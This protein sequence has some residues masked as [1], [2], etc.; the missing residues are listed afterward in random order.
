[1]ATEVTV[2]KAETI[3]M[4]E[5]AMGV[6]DLLRTSKSPMGVNAIAKQCDL[7]PS[8][9]FRILKTLEKTGWVYQ[10]E[11][12]RYITGHKLSFVTEKNNFYM[13]LG[14]AAK[15]VME[16]CTAHHGLAMNLI[17]RNGADCVILEQ[18]LTKS[19][20]NYVPPL[21]STLPYYAC[22]GGKIL[23]CELPDALVESLIRTH[24]M[25]ALTPFTITDP[26]AYI[27]ELKKTAENGYAI[28]FQESSINGSCIAV[29]V[30]DREG[31][32]IASLSFS[33]LIGI[34][35]PSKLLKYLPSLKEASARITQSLYDC[36][37]L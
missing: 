20:I 29:P 35:D 31:T 28:D 24:R 10:L 4:V 22:G 30:R 7:N 26:E 6:L 37:A 1:M 32:I 34:S 33:G 27:A 5:S 25:E 14:D 15:F 17:V 23:L 19:I 21:H 9:S 3:K 2:Q 18:S 16:D 12:D 8:T 13:A 36:W 11:D